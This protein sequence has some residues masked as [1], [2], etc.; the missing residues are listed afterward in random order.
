MPIFL[1][2]PDRTVD[3]DM[4]EIPTVIAG[5][6]GGLSASFGMQMR[7]QFPVVS[8]DPF[9]ELIARLDACPDAVE[10]EPLTA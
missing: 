3:L 9:V 10:C 1:H 2:K 8:D 7:D 5:A 4:R 6:F